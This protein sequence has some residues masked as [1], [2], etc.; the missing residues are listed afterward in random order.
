M[1]MNPSK[2]KYKTSLLFWLF[3]EEMSVVIS[4]ER[5]TYSK[6]F[7]KKIIKFYEKC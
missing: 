5:K 3:I 2:K 7:N 6:K 4:G 1:F